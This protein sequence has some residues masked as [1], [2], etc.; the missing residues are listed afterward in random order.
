M[1]GAL[2][3]DATNG[4]L[5][6]CFDGTGNDDIIETGKKSIIGET[7]DE[8]PTN[9]LL[10]HQD[11]L[12]SENQMWAYILGVG[13]GKDSESKF[14][15]DSQVKGGL[16]E[17]FGTG[18]KARTNA[19]C[20]FLAD[21]YR[22]GVKFYIFGFSRGAFSARLLANKIRK[23]PI[24]GFS[25]IEMLGIW[26][27][28]GSL[29]IPIGKWQQPNLGYDFSIGPNVKYC[30]HAVAIDETLGMLRPT[31]ATP[32]KDSTTQL[33][34]DVIEEVWF[35]GSHADIG[36]G[37]QID[38]NELSRFS[39]LFMLNRSKSKG[40]SING[41]AFETLA[42]SG[43]VDGGEE[44]HSR[45]KKTDQNL[46]DAMVN[47]HAPRPVQVLKWDD[48]FEQLEP[49]STPKIHSSVVQRIILNEEY[50]PENLLTPLML[51]KLSELEQQTPAIRESEILKL[52]ERKYEI[53]GE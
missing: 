41:K 43:A 11:Y 44:L 32:P 39:L 40:L 52:L 7:Y 36:G 27:T 20:E 33:S 1:G 8:G 45:E 34:P 25:E 26:D 30:C 23:K 18:V 6:V 48:K 24:Q 29:G 9:V 5:I 17:I 49:N 47:E 31:L 53:V 13:T 4:N 50:R 10:M 2:S 16:K 3:T 22:P 28:V 19:A 51:Q 12:S 37:W 46:I 15:N 21:N 14:V 42:D 35:A 38:E